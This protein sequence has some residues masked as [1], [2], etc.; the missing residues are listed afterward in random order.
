MTD[1]QEIAFLQS[2]AAAA[3][4]TAM[5]MAADNKDRELNGHQQ[6]FLKPEFD[7]LI[8]QFGLGHN[9]ALIAL[10]LGQ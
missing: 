9:A 3:L 10:G 4:I 7:A 8:N 5:G 1:Q 6:Q 2:Q